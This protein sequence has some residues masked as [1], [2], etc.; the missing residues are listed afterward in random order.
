LESLEIVAIAFVAVFVVRAIVQRMGGGTTIN[1]VELIPV[2]GSDDLAGLFDR[3]QDVKTL[4]FL[5]DPY[6]PVSARAARQVSAFG[7]PVHLINVSAQ[8]DLN[9]EVEQLT[10]IKHESPQ[11]IIFSRGRPF[12]FASHDRITSA[13]LNDAWETPDNRPVPNGE[14]GR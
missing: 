14:A 12:W 8:H 5:H 9:D 7:K 13:K 4:L 6:C 2:T 10:G 3:T 1:D 11:A